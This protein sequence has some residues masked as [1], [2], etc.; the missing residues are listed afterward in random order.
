MRKGRGLMDA[1]NLDMEPR[2]N[3]GRF[4]WLGRIVIALIAF[5]AIAGTVFWFSRE[6]I[7]GNL[8]D[9]ALAQSDLEATYDIVSIGPQQQIIEN[10][11]IGDAA[12]PDLTIERIVAEVDYGLG[13][14]QIGRITAYNPR[15]YGTLRDGSLSFGALD[16]AIY[17]EGDAGLPAL[18][19]K[20]VDARGLIESDFGKI[21]LKLAGEGMLDDGFA[22]KL[23]A[24]APGFGTQTCSSQAAT[25]YGDLTT[26]NGLPEF[27]G[28]VRL[29]GLECEGVS[30]ASAN[31]NADIKTADKFAKL[32]SELAFSGSQL[33]LAGMSGDT[34]GGKARLVIDK[35]GANLAHDISID[36]FV[37]PYGGLE[38]LAADGSLRSAFESGDTEWR[39]DVSGQ[40]FTPGRTAN[41]LIADAR[42]TLNGTLLEPLLTKFTRNLDGAAAGASLAADVTMRQNESGLAVIIPQGRVASRSGET[43]LALSRVSWSQS[44][45]SRTG[46]L[47]GNFITGGAGLPQINGRMQQRG[48]GPLTMRINMASYVEGAN[49]LAIPR[50]EIRQSR[51]G[52]LDFTGIVSASGDIPGGTVT[53]LTLPVAGVWQ[54]T[55]A[56]AL[57]NKCTTARFEALTLYDLALE[58]QS[59]ELCPEPGASAMIAYTDA[60][61]MGISAE[62][63][64]LFGAL[65]GSPIRMAAATG[66]LRYPEPFELTDIAVRIGASENG[67]DMKAA[68]LSGDLRGEDEALVRGSFAGGIAVIDAVPLMFSEIGGN[69]RYQ[70]DALVVQD[71]A[72]TLSDQVVEGEPRFE[73]L[74][75]TDATLT[76]LG[77]NVAA[78][79]SLRHPRTRQ[80]VT[81]VEI[82]HD[83]GSGAGQALLDVPG[84]VFGQGLEPDD[85]SILTRG[86]I[87]FAEGTVSGNGKINWTADNVTSSGT[88]STRDFDFAAAFGPVEGLSGDIV[89]TDLLSLTTAP[90][91]ELTIESVNPGIEVLAGKIVYSL[92]NGEVISVK[93]GR[94]PFMGGELIL[95]PTKAYYGGTAEQSYVFEIKG[96]DAAKFVT[97]LELTNLGATGTFDGTIP[98]VFDLDG[99]GRI[100]GGQLSSRDPGGNVA[101]VGELLY[102]DLGAMGNYAFQSLRSLDYNRMSIGLNGDLAGEII[103]N[104]T[105]DGVRQ[106]EGTSQNF[107]TKRLAKLPIRFKINV[108]SQNFYQLATMVRSFWDPSLLGDPVSRGTL[109]GSDG[110]RQLKIPENDN[111]PETP[112]PVEDD[113]RRP[114]EPVVQAGE[115]EGTL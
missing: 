89:F 12:R 53:D 69:W 78:N 105:F 47:S 70:D 16:P 31:I 40:N 38:A 106:G 43:L 19:I 76:L 27:S 68:S 64:E 82:A 23:A 1:D 62:N 4:W 88:F 7:A 94:W 13:A 49:R 21:G 50:F 8:I 65:A 33:G 11:V 99:N 87:A 42:A 37:T 6:R 115:S 14:P 55:G 74:Q 86:V 48:R 60:L 9:D 67:I 25:L 112:T 3:S 104:F 15:I 22:A 18:D 51:S 30:L 110:R 29:R 61:T 28:P 73:P 79:A 17:G 100:E 109:P 77:N 20:I 91:Q 75:T 108:R 90:D 36:N 45:A 10:F 72:L 113:I 95:Q 84:V 80:M 46:S 111:V 5:L 41:A 44:G 101:Y 58:G 24:T 59:L 96:L 35:D 52:D 83:L 97:Q 71:A 92:T 54:R 81:S 26:D 98:V 114:D 85:L 63:L 107:V 66:T 93:E 57:G 102:E 32:E 39:G 103:T 2:R 34:L 56:F